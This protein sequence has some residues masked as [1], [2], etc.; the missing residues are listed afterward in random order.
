MTVPA[1]P[2][3]LVSLLEK[4][5]IPM[6]RLR[7]RYGGLLSLVDTLIG[8]V[9]NA[10]PYL[11]IWP[12]A[13]RAYNVMVPNFL[14]LPPLLWG[15]AT[16]SSTIGL[17]IYAASLSA[18]CPYCVA[19]TCTF[20]LRRGATAEEVLSTLDGA[21]ALSERDRAAV[22]VARAL[23][24][25]P[26]AIE[27]EH[28]RALRSAFSVKDE[29]WI[30]LSIAMMG[31]LNKTMDGLGVPLEAPVVAEVNDVLAGS[32][33]TPGKHWD[34]EMPA[35]LPPPPVDSLVRRLGIIRHAPQVLS[36]DLKWTH[37]V[38]DR[39]PAVG[40]FLRTNTGH[41]FPV[42]GKIQH[43]RAVRAIAMIIR[44]HFCES[45][46]GRDKKLGAGLIY[47]E[48]IGNGSVADALRAA[49]AKPTDDARVASLARALAP[50]PTAVDASVVDACRELS[51]AAIV[52]VTTF[53]ALLQMLHRLERYFGT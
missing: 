2:A 32:G 21:A 44:D 31:W 45:A 7:E 11:E 42:L 6:A 28:R 20:A 25:V 53:I 36:F 22:R 33:W 10:D 37:G 38:P 13:F 14:N 4:D 3:V 18:G 43:R 1:K 35:T 15:F 19:H 48:A 41:H 5:A 12:P 47:V 16:P 49:G 23:S 39:W 24:V 46:I 30:V 52:E 29:E 40:D 17:A 27:E 26:A 50:S 9:P 8:V 34:G 51:P